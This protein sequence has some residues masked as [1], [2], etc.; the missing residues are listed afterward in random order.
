M[1][2]QLRDYVEA[3][4][5]PVYWILD[6]IANG[7]DPATG[8]FPTFA[9]KDDWLAL[10]WVDAFCAYGTFSVQ[11]I[12]GYA[13]LAP[14]FSYMS[15]LAHEHGHAI[16]L[17]VHPGHNNS[18]LTEKP[19][20]IPRRDGQTLR[21]Y[22]HAAEDARADIIMVTSF[23]EW[24]ETT[25]VEPSRNWNDPYQYLK[26]LAKWKDRAFTLPAE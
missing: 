25:V 4:V 20:V 21:E 15:W 18:R 3:R 5:G 22:L 2:T 12:H 19:W 13:E 16:M 23:N 24:P 6:K 26:I 17:P 11:R 8:G 9:I 1:A 10:D 7:R 14:R